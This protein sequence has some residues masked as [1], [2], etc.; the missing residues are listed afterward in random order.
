MGNILRRYID[1]A[2]HVKRLDDGPEH[3]TNDADD[4]HMDRD[5]EHRDDDLLGA[6]DDAEHGEHNQ[7]DEEP[8]DPNRQGLIRQ[9][10]GAHLVYKREGEDG[11][12]EELWIYNLRPSMRDELKVRRDILAGTDIPVNKT[13][14]PDGSQ[15]YEVWT[16]G[17]AQLVHIQGLPN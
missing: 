5:E 16:A 6:M 4:Q 10:P 11:T 7:A 12:Y 17:N 3:G 1:E 14:S 13:S 9:V 2:I 15:T 8:Q